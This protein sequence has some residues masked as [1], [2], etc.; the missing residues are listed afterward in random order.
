MDDSHHPG[1]MRH[2]D[3][4]VHEETTDLGATLS[5]ILKSPKRSSMTDAAIDP[6]RKF[7]P[8]MFTHAGSMFWIEVLRKGLCRLYAEG[9]ALAYH[10]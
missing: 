5:A 7:D 3:I 10:S 2:R 8:A 4:R 6:S 9:L 1:N